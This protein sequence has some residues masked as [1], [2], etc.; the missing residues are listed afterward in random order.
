M[1]TSLAG[2]TVLV[3]GRPSGIA[4][5]VVEAALAEGAEVTVAGRD[6]AKLREAYDEQAYGENV[7]AETIDITDD[8]SIEALA[9]RMGSVDHVVTTASARARGLLRDLDRE[10]LRLSFDTK[11]IG[12]VM[13]A[14]HFAPRINEGGSFTLFS[15][16]HAF[17]PTVGYLG[18]GI[19]NGAADFLTRSLALEM[20]PIRVNSISPGVI[21]TGIW[22]AFGEEGKNEYFEHFRSHNPARR[23]GTVDDIAQAVIFAMTNGF[24]TGVTLRVDG[25]EPLI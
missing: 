10:D 3:I 1:G 7:H 9:E 20:G 18:V 5:A 22:D 12:P 4:R 21:D 6:A 16:V 23:I 14:K 2:K 13:L 17:K 24:L 8:A 15:G 19:T 25:G 11:V